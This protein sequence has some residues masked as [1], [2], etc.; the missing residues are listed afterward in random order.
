MK[1]EYFLVMLGKLN[2]PSSGNSDGALDNIITMEALDGASNPIVKGC[3]MKEWKKRGKTI[4]KFFGKGKMLTKSC[5]KTRNKQSIEKR[6]I[7][8]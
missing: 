1:K 8:Q 3:K 6:T 4:E 5:K 7:E 2:L